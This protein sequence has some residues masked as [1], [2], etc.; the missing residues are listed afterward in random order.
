MVKTLSF[1]CR[2]HAFDSL[3]RELRP[4]ML[5]DMAKKKEK[6]IIK[7]VESPIRQQ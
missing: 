5:Q 3:V 2:G 4:C 6:K 7:E 1:H